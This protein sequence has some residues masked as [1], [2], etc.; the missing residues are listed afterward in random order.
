MNVLMS[1][2]YT[3]TALG[4]MERAR[5]EE[6]VH[7]RLRNTASHIRIISTQSTPIIRRSEHK[8]LLFGRLIWVKM[9]AIRAIYN[10]SLYMSSSSALLPH[11]QLSILPHGLHIHRTPNTELIP[12]QLTDKRYIVTLSCFAR[13]LT[14]LSHVSVHD[15]LQLLQSFQSLTPLL[16]V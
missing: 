16:Q 15:C 6:H 3:Y 8:R 7:K 12:Q 11:S 5:I 9:L 13:H 10:G 1:N 2:E 4:S 14:A